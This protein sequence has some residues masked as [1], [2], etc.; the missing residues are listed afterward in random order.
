MKSKPALHQVDDLLEEIRL[1]GI[2]KDGTRAGDDPDQQ[3]GGKSDPTTTPVW[4]SGCAIIHSDIHALERVE[5]MHDLRRGKF[6][7]FVGVN[8]LREGLDLPEVSLVAILDADK[9]G[10]LRRTCSFRRSDAPREM[11]MAKSSCTRTRSL[12]QFRPV[13][14]DPNVRRIGFSWN[15]NEDN[16]ITPETIKN[17][18][19]MSSVQF[20]K[21]TI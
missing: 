16:N 14:I 18:S 8:L 2:D 20:M 15:I 17:R 12:N 10:F 9:E 13:L 7:V 11:S 6:D 4:A 21:P 19:A 1:R 3:H 5:I